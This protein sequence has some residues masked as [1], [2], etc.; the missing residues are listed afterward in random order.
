MNNIIT[1]HIS[2]SIFITFYPASNVF[3]T[4]DIISNIIVIYYFKV[5]LS[6]KNWSIEYLTFIK[7][8]VNSA[9]NFVILTTLTNP[10]LFYKSR[11]LSS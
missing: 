11:P 8:L 6:I 7:S 10:S 2:S 3:K 5:G 9:S 1:L 4:S